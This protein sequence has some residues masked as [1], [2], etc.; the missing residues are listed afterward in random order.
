MRLLNVHRLEF[1]EF[2]RNVPKYVTTSHRWR[3]GNEA[4]ISDIR[5]KH[6]TDNSGFKKVEGFAQCVRKH[7]GFVDWMWI[8]TC[9]VNQDSSQEVDEAVNSMFQW[10]SNAEVCLAY[11]ADVSNAKD[12]DQF[13]RSEW[14]RRG[15]TLQELLAPAFVVF[16]SKN[17]QIIGCKGKSKYTRSELNYMENQALEQT[18]ADITGVPECVLHDYEQSKRFTTEERMAWIVGRDTTKREDLY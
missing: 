10:Y 2:N 14:F 4:M 6:N 18:I 1:E 9:C 7:M 5:S 11:L 16:F 13:R 8:D 12:M 17:W 3:A 15:W